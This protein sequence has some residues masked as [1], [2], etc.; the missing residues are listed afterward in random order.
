VFGVAG[1]RMHAP[2]S[3][4]V[5]AQPGTVRGL[6]A[7]TDSI[8]FLLGPRGMACHGIVAADGG[9]GLSVWRGGGSAPRQHS[10]RDGLTLSVEPACA[11]C[12][13]G[14]ACPFF[15]ALA[16]S[17]GWPCHAVAPAREVVVRQGARLVLFTDPPGVAGDGWPS[18]G[19]DP[20][21]GL[22]ELVGGPNN[23][24][25]RATCTLPAADRRTCTTSL[26]AILAQNR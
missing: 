21:N 16:A 12:R 3:I 13:A 5:E 10:R 19:P 15:T 4:S 25:A 9:R 24:V 6:A 7:Y 1:E 18:G 11:S 23:E 14:E 2:R 20:A 22:A 8:D 17:L 26:N